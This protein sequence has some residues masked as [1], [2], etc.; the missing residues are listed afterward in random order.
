M[1]A[2]TGN[3]A[4]EEGLGLEVLICKSRIGKYFVGL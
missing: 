1:A 4:G 3:Q 2:L